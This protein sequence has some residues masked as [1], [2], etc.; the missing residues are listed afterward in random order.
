MSSSKVLKWVTGAFELFLAIPFLG[1]LIVMGSSYT[2]LGVMFILHIITLAL[3]VRNNEPFYGSV[4]G[5][6]TSVVAWIPFV[7]WL[8]HL[9]SGIFLMVNAAQKSSHDSRR[10]M[11]F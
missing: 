1:G 8:L 7:G 11:Q 4:L 10:P 3:A 9:L 6:V 2:V 5:V